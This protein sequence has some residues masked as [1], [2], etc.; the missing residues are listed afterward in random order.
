[1]KLRNTPSAENLPAY[2]RP[3]V[4]GNVI[5]GLGSKE[6]QR[7]R[8]VFHDFG[9]PGF[10]WSGM[11][12]FFLMNNTWAILKMAL[13]YRWKLRRSAGPLAKRR[14]EVSDPVR[15]A[16]DVKDQARSFGAGIVGITEVLPSDFYADV[17]PRYRYAICIGAPMDREEMLQVPHERAG[18]EVQRVYGLVA[19]T[20][21][22]LA[23]HIRSLGWPAVACGDPRSTDLL[24]IPLAVRAGLGELGKH[25]S[26]I[27]RE[28]GSNVRLSAVLTDLPMAIDAPVDIAV[29]DLCNGCRRCTLDCPP[30]AIADS[31]QWVRGEHRWYVDFDRCTPY[32]S[33]TYGCAICIE[34]CPW[35]EPGRGFRLSEMLLAKRNKLAGADTAAPGQTGE[36]TA[37]SVSL[38]S[39]AARR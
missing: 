2:Q 13:S 26:L 8:R 9:R 35:S 19:S 32:F 17:E 15:M 14:F 33:A 31:K 37:N 24:Q 34:V 22:D 1:M 11:N 38:S 20:A 6:P 7:A 29:D 28:Y 16:A 27:C 21:V 18:I 23:E 30:M 4:S 10:A 25:G 39:A 12:G 3:P 5:N 36:I